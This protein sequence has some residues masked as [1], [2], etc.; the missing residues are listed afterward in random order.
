MTA[1]PTP[2]L[3]VE[4]F[5]HLPDPDLGPGWNSSVPAEL[6]AAAISEIQRLRSKR[7]EQNRSDLLA[8]LDEHGQEPDMDACLCGWRSPDPFSAT[9][10]HHVD[11]LADVLMSEQVIRP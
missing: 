6:V 3:V 5:K 11:H 9:A 7:T 4:L 1:Q 8:L 10:A 2:D